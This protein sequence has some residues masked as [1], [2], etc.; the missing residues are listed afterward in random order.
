MSKPKLIVYEFGMCFYLTEILEVGKET[1]I[2]NDIAAHHK[3][4]FINGQKTISMATI[5]S[6]WTVEKNRIVKEIPLNDLILYSHWDN[7]TKLYF[8]LRENK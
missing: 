1:V 7:K 6:P 2:V 8:K 5:M 3:S 4:E